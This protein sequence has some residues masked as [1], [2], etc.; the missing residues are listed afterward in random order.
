MV[1]H[2]NMSS[3]LRKVTVIPNFIET[4]KMKQNEKAEDYVPNKRTREKI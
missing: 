4:E 1:P 3:S 2:K